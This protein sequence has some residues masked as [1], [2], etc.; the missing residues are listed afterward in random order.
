[1]KWQRLVDVPVAGQHASY[2]PGNGHRE[3][4]PPADA[5]QAVLQVGTAKVSPH[6]YNREGHD[7]GEYQIDRCSGP[8]GGMRP[9]GSTAVPSVHIVNLVDRILDEHGAGLC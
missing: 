3:H 8:Y 2:G 5:Q 9:I 1:M 7:N 4:D 6:E